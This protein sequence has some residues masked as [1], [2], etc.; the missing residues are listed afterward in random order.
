M[1]QIKG[2]VLIKWEIM[3]KMQNWG[4]VIEKF[5]PQKPRTEPE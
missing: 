4:E 1:I 2:H 5:S 3:I